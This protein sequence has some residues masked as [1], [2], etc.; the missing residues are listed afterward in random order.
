MIARI[1]SPM[2]FVSR[3]L[4]G[5]KGKN[6]LELGEEFPVP[7][8]FVV[9]SEE[10]ADFFI[11]NGLKDKIEQIL[12]QNNDFRKIEKSVQEEFAKGSFSKGTISDLV[13]ELGILQS[14]SQDSQAIRSSGIDEDGNSNSFAG[15]HDS[16]FANL[17]DKLLLEY[18]KRCYASAFNAVALK[19]RQD[20][21]LGLPKG[22]AVV[23]QHLKQ[24]EVGFVAYTAAPFDYDLLLIEAAPGHCKSVVDGRAID[25]FKVQKR[26]G[27][28]AIN[29]KINP[30]KQIMWQFDAKE[31]KLKLVPIP[32]KYIGNTACLTNEQ[33]QE[34]VDVS[35]DIEACYALGYP[36]ERKP[37]DIEGGFD[38]NRRLWITQSRDITGMS[39]KPAD[40]VLPNLSKIIGNSYNVGNGGIYEGPAIIV[41]EVDPNGTD[42]TLKGNADIEKLDSQFSSGYVLVTPE[43]NP[44]LDFYLNHC[45][46]IVA[47]ECGIMSHAGATARERGLIFIG[48]VESSDKKSLQSRLNHGDVVC[49]A[50]NKEKGIVGYK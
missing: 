40:I 10:Y 45:K 3:E 46:A 17:D 1:G 21:K 28:Y 24:F 43:T 13:N 18:L 23:V 5:G 15:Q 35:L 25:A 14:V 12:D 34:I 7:E 41:D 44:T 31:G 50:A 27:I 42:F 37:Q 16:F 48:C 33:I 38:Y 9:S 11:R 29:A 39:F 26:N 8:G 49:V 22:M 36:D 47:T 30:N 20:H 4:F 19:Y 2:P 6:L 32:K